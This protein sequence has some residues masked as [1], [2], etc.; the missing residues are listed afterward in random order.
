MQSAKASEPCTDR[1]ILNDRMRA[2]LRVYR[3]AVIDLELQAGE[4]RFP[5][6][7]KNLE[8]ARLAYEASRATLE[9]HVAIHGCEY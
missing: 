9:A 8:R 7:H 5:I 4:K 1:Q 3:Q 6:A 2:D